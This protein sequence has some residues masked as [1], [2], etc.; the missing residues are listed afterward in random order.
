MVIARINVFRIIITDILG[1]GGHGHEVYQLTV[2]CVV[3]AVTILGNHVSSN[4]K[5]LSDFAWDVVVE[6][7]TVLVNNKGYFDVTLSSVKNSLQLVKDVFIIY[8]GEEVGIKFGCH[9][10]GRW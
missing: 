7:V 9:I 1:R 10:R 5:T 2:A 6:V 4:Q 8:A 3:F